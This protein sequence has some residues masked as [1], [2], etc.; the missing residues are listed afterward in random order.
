MLYDLPGVQVSSSLEIKSFKD[1][2]CRRQSDNKLLGLHSVATLPLTKKPIFT[3]HHK[4]I[5]IATLDDGWQFSLPNAPQFAVH[6]N[7]N[8]DEILATLTENELEQRIMLPLIR[9]AVECA[10]AEHGVISLH[11]ASVEINGQAVCFTAPSGVGKS[12]RAMKWAEVLGAS[13]ISGDRPSVKLDNDHAVV[14]GVPWD[15]K[16]RIYRNVQMPLKTICVIKRGN[17]AAVRPLDKTEARQVLMQQTFIPMWDTEAATYVM[18]VIRKLI[19]RVKIVELTCDIDDNATK[20]AYD[21]IF[22]HPNEIAEES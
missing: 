21:L 11:S 12:T 7:K 22:N 6:L 10:S 16:E 17:G 20:Q 18:T 19:D 3:A 5:D 8:R 4:E 2:S 13:L 9:T 15:G 14:C 1:F